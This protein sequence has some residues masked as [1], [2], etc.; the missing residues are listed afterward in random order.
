MTAIFVA[1][2]DEFAES[3]RKVIAHND[4]EI[5]VFFV[6]GSFY[7]WYNECAH[8]GGPVCQGKLFGKVIEP[9][10]EDKSVSTLAYAPGVVHLVCPWHGYE[11]DLKTGINAGDRNLRLRKVTVEVK[12]SDVYVL[13]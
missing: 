11:Y 1:H 13:V 8:R 4:T 5:G 3:K 6:D 12:G 7:A 10:G 9:L 2:V